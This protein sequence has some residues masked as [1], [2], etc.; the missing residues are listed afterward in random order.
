[1]GED[2]D[3]QRMEAV[4]HTY[5]HTGA[6]FIC[7]PDLRGDVTIIEHTINCAMETDARVTVPCQAILDF[8]AEHVRRDRIAVIERGAMTYL[9]RKAIAR[10]EQATT[11]ELLGIWNP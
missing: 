10:L 4:S 6:T 9:A 11:A 2:R 1:M 3:R 7:N 8:V 5:Q